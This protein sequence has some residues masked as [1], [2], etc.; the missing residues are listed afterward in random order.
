MGAVFFLCTSL[1]S[2][3]SGN[4]VQD[5]PHHSV[6]YFIMC[7]FC[8]AP[9]TTC[10]SRLFVPPTHW[11]TLRQDYTLLF[12]VVSCVSIRNHDL[13]GKTPKLGHKNWNAGSTDEA[14]KSFDLVPHWKPLCHCSLQYTLNALRYTNLWNIL[15]IMNISSI[16][17]IGSCS[18]GIVP[19]QK[20][21]ANARDCNLL[22]NVVYLWGIV[23]SLIVPLLMENM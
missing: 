8:I 16:F 18:C 7:L 15:Y 9:A 17:W 2:S 22:S 1:E 4:M 10:L 5:Q 19:Y 13:V 3:S 21:L 14:N 11:I 6:F 23:M 12:H 20:D